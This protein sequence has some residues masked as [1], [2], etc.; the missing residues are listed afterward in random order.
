LEDKG[1][2]S[3]VEEWLQEVWFGDEVL[4][5]TYLINSLQDQLIIRIAKEFK[6]KVYHT[7][8]PPNY[9]PT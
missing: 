3:L 9:Q 7:T 4:W 6:I 5:W 8:P 1:K 2:R